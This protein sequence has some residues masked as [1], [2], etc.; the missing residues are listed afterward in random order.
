MLPLLLAADIPTSD[1]GQPG[2]R[3]EITLGT[4]NPRTSSPVFAVIWAVRYQMR[5]TRSSPYIGSKGMGPRDV[6]ECN[7]SLAAIYAIADLTRLPSVHRGNE[8]R[9]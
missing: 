7:Y 9:N 8:A 6:T 3:E 5:A 4:L 2:S 1:E